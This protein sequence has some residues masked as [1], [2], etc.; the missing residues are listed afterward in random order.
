MKLKEVFVMLFY[1]GYLLRLIIFM[2]ISSAVYIVYYG[3]TYN[4][5]KIGLPSI[6]IDVLF[7]ASV[8]GVCYASFVPF[9]NST[10]RVKGTMFVF[11]WILLG[12]V[13][14]VI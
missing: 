11:L 8:E 12:A 9:V 7:L 14:L 13:I 10:K 4:S 3:I 2:I 1:E 5:G 6:Q